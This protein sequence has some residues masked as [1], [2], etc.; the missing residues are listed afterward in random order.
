MAEIKEIIFQRLKE[1]RL[2]SKDS[3]LLDYFVEKYVSDY[4][5]KD[6]LADIQ[7]LS[8]QVITLVDTTDLGKTVLKYQNRWGEVLLG[9]TYA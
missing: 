7:E 6:H 3:E 9:K 2:I 8:K 4:T 5:K 1:T